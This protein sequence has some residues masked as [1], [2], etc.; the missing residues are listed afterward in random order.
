MNRNPMVRTSLSLG[1]APLLTFLPMAGQTLVIGNLK[2][3]MSFFATTRMSSASTIMIT[4]I[5]IWAPIIS[6]GV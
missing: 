2:P 1:R 6:S 3:L 4:E 5:R